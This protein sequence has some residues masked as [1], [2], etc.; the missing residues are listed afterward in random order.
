MPTTRKVQ[1]Q[2]VA[3]LPRALPDLPDELAGWRWSNN[4][5]NGHSFL[6]H[7]NSPVTYTTRHYPD[8]DRAIAEARRYVLSQ[9]KNKAAKRVEFV[10]LDQIRADGGTQARAGLDES[11]IEEYAATYQELSYQ[12]NGLDRMPPIVVYY[13][14]TDHWLADGFH[15]LSAYRR[16]LSDGEPSASPHALRAEIRQGTRRDAVLYACGANAS[17]GL[18]RTNA[19]KRRAVLALLSD[20]EWGQWSDSEIA[21]RCQVS[22]TFVSEL[23][24]DLYPATLQDSRTVQR[25]GT[26]Y[27]MTPAARPEVAP[28]AAAAFDDARRR[29]AALGWKLERHGVWFKLSDPQGRHYATTPD[30]APQLRTLAVFEKAAAEAKPNIP[31]PDQVNHVVAVREILIAAESAGERTGT[32]L[33]QEAYAHARQMHDLALRQALF[34]EIDA[35]VDGAKPAAAP[36]P[37]PAAKATPTAAPAPIYYCERCGADATQRVKVGG[38]Q[39]HRCA[40]CGTLPIRPGRPKTGDSSAVLAYLQDIEGYA[41]ALEQYIAGHTPAPAL[42]TEVPV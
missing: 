25:G 9:P 38:I 11:T 29:F 32:R 18:R 31:E 7:P 10:G 36:A 14:G 33:Y 12:Q 2:D 34:A 39:E 42:E 26:T 23:R 40:S 5:K 28:T 13:D 6:M 20:A 1:T 41:T 24:R 30:L 16:F 15:R 22:H 17:H 3:S 8:P 37:A 21:R 4:P 35:A 27:Q 19:D